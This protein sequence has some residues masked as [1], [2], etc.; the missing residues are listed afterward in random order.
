MSGPVGVSPSWQEGAVVRLHDML[1]GPE[2]DP[3]VENELARQRREREEGAPQPTHAHLGRPGFR[4]TTAS[5]PVCNGL[6]GPWPARLE[7]LHCPQCGEIT[8][9]GEMCG[10]CLSDMA[11]YFYPDEGGEG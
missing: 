10:E 8:S 1:G 4:W 3:E 6:V 5:C 11:D 7:A 9:D 2:P